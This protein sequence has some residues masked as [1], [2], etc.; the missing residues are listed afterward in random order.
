MF[1]MTGY[2][3]GTYDKGGAEIVCEIKTVNNRYLDVSFKMPRVF[4]PLEETLREI[5]RSYLTR[6]HADVFISYKDKRETRGDFF[7]DLPLAKSYVRAAQT[8]ANA[9]PEA[10]N[11]LT[12]TALMKLPDVIKTEEADADDTAG[13]GVKEAL[14][15][16]LGN[17][18][19]MRKKEGE[20]LKNDMLSR[21]VTI[22]NYVNDIALRAPLVAKDY[23]EKLTARVKEALSGAAIDEGRLLTEAAVFTDKSNI[24]E[25]IT[26][27]YS[28][29]AQFRAI[30]EEGVVG[31]KLDFLVQEFNREA[32][33][34]CSK[35]NDAALTKTGLALKNEIEKVREQVQNVE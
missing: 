35:S 3:K 33:T 18:N 5:V 14:C 24:D 31:R 16:A 7:V 6:G 19:V 26:R 11:D 29:I 17:L 13:E 1:S 25:E 23:F 30:C 20:K 10:E 34:A 9:F 8:L 12:L 2:G 15:A 32:N 22:E 4:L 28:H 21:M 27:L